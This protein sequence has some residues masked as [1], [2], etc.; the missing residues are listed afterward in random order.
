MGQKTITDK[1]NALKDDERDPPVSRNSQGKPTKEISFPQVGRNILPPSHLKRVIPKH[2]FV[3][4]K[5]GT[6]KIKS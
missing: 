3:P 1:D 5:E 4:L 2:D 6:S